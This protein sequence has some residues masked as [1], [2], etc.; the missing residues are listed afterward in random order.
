MYCKNCGISI[1]ENSKFCSNCGN[2]IIIETNFNFENDRRKEY[3]F[4][5][6]KQL[7]ALNIE[8]IKTKINIMNDKINIYEEKTILYFIKR[9][10]KII[11]LSVKDIK[12]VNLKN[13]ID[14]IDLIYAIVFG[15]LGFLFPPVFIVTIVCLITGF[16]QKV[17]IKLKNGFEVFIQTEKNN[18]VQEFIKGIEISIE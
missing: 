2:E 17:R 18:I 3:N 4:S 11:E 8:L 6:V 14:T 1:D 5:K 12:E 13:A 16:G 15:V 9:K 10:P 7:G